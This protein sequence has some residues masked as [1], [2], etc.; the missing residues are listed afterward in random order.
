MADSYEKLL[1]VEVDERRFKEAVDHPRLDAD[2]RPVNMV[3]TLGVYAGKWAVIELG[4]SSQAYY[5]G[6]N[7]SPEQRMARRYS[8]ELNLRLRNDVDAAL[9]GR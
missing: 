5:G 6:Q 1:P 3:A 7:L 9:V 8:V 2:G 4:V